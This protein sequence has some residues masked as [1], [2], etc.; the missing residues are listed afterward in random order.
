[1]KNGAIIHSVIFSLKHEKGSS[2]EQRF[3]EDG[4]AALS[5]IPTVKEFQVFREISPKNT[6]DFG[7]SMRFD[8]RED[9]EAYNAH[10]QHVAF[11]RDRWDPEVIQFL[12]IDY[13]G[14]EH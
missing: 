1:M 8:S 2:A 10:P 4:R 5:S 13:A 12:E 6:Y 14:Y 9:Y 11:V 7:F 3:L